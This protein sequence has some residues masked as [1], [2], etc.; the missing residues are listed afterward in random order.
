[1]IRNATMAER[2]QIQRDA[3]DALAKVPADLA[4]KCEMRKV[5]LK[6]IDAA[7]RECA[8]AG[9]PIPDEIQCLAGLQKIQYVLAYPEQ[10]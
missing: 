5:S 6:G 10:K 7:L 8:A 2:G 3:L 1:M 4:G 9:T